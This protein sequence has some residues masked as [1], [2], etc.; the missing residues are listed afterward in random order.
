MLFRPL[1]GQAC[2]PLWDG[3]GVPPLL[4]ALHQP[5]KD[6]LQSR[7]TFFLVEEAVTSQSKL[8]LSVNLSKRI[9]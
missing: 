3:K 9:S 6:P 4:I 8:D 2:E 7:A 1:A 5:N